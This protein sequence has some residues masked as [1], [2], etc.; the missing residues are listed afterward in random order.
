MRSFV[1]RSLLLSG[2][3]GKTEI[4]KKNGKWNGST[5]RKNS[6]FRALLLPLSLSLS[7]GRERER[8]RER[9][10]AGGEEAGAEVEDF[11]LS[12]SL[13][14]PLRVSSSSRRT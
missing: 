1:N 10:R 8:E 2:S 11:F 14:P 3:L 12:L 4:E 5:E 13:S 6:C 9:E 7:R